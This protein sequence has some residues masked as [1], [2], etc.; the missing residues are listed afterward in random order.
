MDNPFPLTLHT[1]AVLP[2]KFVFLVSR[3]YNTITRILVIFHTHF[4]VVVTIL[5]TEDPFVQ[6][7][8]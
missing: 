2:R 8:I 6:D 7:V 3:S 4:R 1:R 5:S